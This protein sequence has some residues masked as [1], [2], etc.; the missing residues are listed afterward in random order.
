MEY[1]KKMEFKRLI[2][3]EDNIT[4]KELKKELIKYRDYIKNTCNCLYCTGQRNFID[5]FL[6]FWNGK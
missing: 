2:N 4:K 3:F 1:F 5:Y 6:G